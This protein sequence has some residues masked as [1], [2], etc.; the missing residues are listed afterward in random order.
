MEFEIPSHLVLNPS[1]ES[2]L[3]ATGLSQLE[4]YKFPFQG[5][6]KSIISALSDALDLLHYSNLSCLQ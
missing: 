6:G 5:F 3:G 2:C 1:A 4:N